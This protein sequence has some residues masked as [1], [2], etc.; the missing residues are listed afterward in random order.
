MTDQ[1]EPP[2]KKTRIEAPEPEDPIVSEEEPIQCNEDEETELAELS[3]LLTEIRKITRR[4]E[5]LIKLLD[6]TLEETRK[7]KTR[8]SYLRIA[9]RKRR[10]AESKSPRKRANKSSG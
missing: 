5:E 10:A 8:L 3:Q 7:L 6:D 1:S 9:P 4:N 2:T